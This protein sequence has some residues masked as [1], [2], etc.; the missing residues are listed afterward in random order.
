MHI[1]WYYTLGVEAHA[2]HYYINERQILLT[3][4]RRLYRSIICFQ[5]LHQHVQKKETYRAKKKKKCCCCLHTAAAAQKSISFSI[6]AECLQLH[7]AS[8]YII[9]R[10]SADVLLTAKLTFSYIFNSLYVYKSSSSSIQQQMYLIPSLSLCVCA[11]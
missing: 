7:A 9:S 4:G 2:R 5:S 3:A 11:Y 8:V 10:S 6:T 1:E